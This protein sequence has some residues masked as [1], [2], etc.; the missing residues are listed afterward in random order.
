MF[1]L[2]IPRAAADTAAPFRREWPEKPCVGVPIRRRNSCILSTKCD[3]EKGP[4][5]LLKR[6]RFW[7]RGCLV[8]SCFRARTGHIV[9][10]DDARW[11]ST[12]SLYGSVFEDGSRRVIE[13]SASLKVTCCLDRECDREDAGSQLSQVNSPARRNAEKPTQIAV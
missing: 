2:E 5:G 9:D 7:G 11:M 4:M 3:F 13:P 12:P 6:A 10:D 8:K 1:S